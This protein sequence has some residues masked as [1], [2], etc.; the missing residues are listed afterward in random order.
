MS[1]QMLREIRKLEARLDDFLN[2]EEAFVGELRD[3]V[4]KFK[5]LTVKMAEIMSDPRQIEKLMK[6]KLEAIKA[7]SEALKK[8]SRAEHEKSHLLESYGALIQAL[9]EEFQS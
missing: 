1:E 6:L 3:C 8:E 4:V 7:F 9:E 2:S 5:E